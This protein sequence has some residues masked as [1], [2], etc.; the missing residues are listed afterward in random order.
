VY[1]ALA[2][3]YEQRGYPHAI[4]EHHQGGTAGYGAR[5][6]VAT[7]ET[8]DR[9]TANM[10]LAWNPSI[11]GAKIEDTF[12]L[13][14]DNSLENLSFDTHFPHVEID[15]RMRPVPLER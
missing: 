14:A 7:P 9:L 6:I 1:N 13:N 2:T 8:S 4:Q 3:A 12:V 15:G 10:I 5:E 11:P